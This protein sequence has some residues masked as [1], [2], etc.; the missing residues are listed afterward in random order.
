M[1]STLRSPPARATRTA[2]HHG[3]LR[4]TL[5]DAAADL[6]A[7]GGI[8]AVGMREIARRASV[9]HAAPYRHYA[10]REA[11]LADLAAIGFE[12]LAARFA[13]LP[14]LATPDRRLVDMARAYVDFARQ[15]PQLWRLMFGN[16]LDKLEYPA[17]LEASR[18]VLATL[19]A[20]VEALGVPAPA[21]HQTLAA[22]AFAHGVARLVLD[23]RLDAHL[24]T[25]I[26]ADALVQ[27]A[28]RIFLRGLR[29]P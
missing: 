29:T 17:L 26:D 5:L 3:E 10:S 14:P 20:T 24:D 7:N 15:Q 27:E 12:Q 2:Y 6:L 4:Q 23:H 11:L 21:T 13:A 19:R 28:A 22:W 1:N 25:P 9:S 18:L 8:D 16:A